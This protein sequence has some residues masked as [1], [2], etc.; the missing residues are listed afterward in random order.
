MTSPPAARLLAA[1]DLLH[2]RGRVTGAELAQHL[3]VDRRTARRYIQRLIEMG[4]PVVADR[5]RDGAYRLEAGFKLP[6]LMFSDDEALALAV[7]LV[8]ARDLGLGEARLGVHGALA[9]LE[10]VMP[11][12]LRVRL[13]AVT[14]A[15]RLDL[16][17]NAHSS[18]HGNALALLSEAAQKQQRVWLQY[19]AAP[20]LPA[21]GEPDAGAVTERQFDCFGLA[22][23][24]GHW[25]AVGHCHLRRAQRS[26]RLDRV[27]AVRLV[28]ASFAPPPSFDALHALKH[29]LALLPG[30]H[31]ALI[32][33][34]TTLAQ[35]QRWIDPSMGVLTDSS[36]RRSPRVELRLHTDDLAW[37]ARV[38]AG[39][40]FALQV[41]RPRAL[42]EALAGHA[43]RLLSPRGARRGA[44]RHDAARSS[45]SHARRRT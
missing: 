29:S 10:R 12:A 3:Q 5:G 19:R 16:G 18:P 30:R 27:L 6:P 8:A 45:T 37:L 2:A 36:T 9:K 43:R 32:E 28:P 40:P 22:F 21:A 23:Y 44:M 33:L 17:G 4:V 26:F 11:Q 31:S 42:A 41:R 7:G 38:L 25:Y 13:Q 34:H 14:R 1:L 39:L 35:A 24:L 20:P 15:I